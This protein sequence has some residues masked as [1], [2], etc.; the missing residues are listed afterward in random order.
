MTDDLH[1]R[2]IALAERLE[3]AGKWVS[4]DGRISEPDAAGLVGVSQRTFR[5]W[6]DEG[7]GPV[8]VLVGRRLTFRIADVLRWLD[9]RT[10]NPSAANGNSRKDAERAA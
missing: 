1:S 3:R 5:N 8:F 9:E 10:H 6:R 2:V 7:R 4:L